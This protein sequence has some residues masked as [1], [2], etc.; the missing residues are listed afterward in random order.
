MT[1]GDTAGNYGKTTEFI[2]YSTKG[3]H[4]LNGKR[5]NNILEFKRVNRK[6]QIHQNQKPVKLLE[7]LISKSTNKGGTVLDPFGGGGSTLIACE[8]T[9]RTCYMMELE[10]KYC[11]R[12]I[13]RYN[14]YVSQ[15]R[16]I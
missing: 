7:Y 13:E 6:K 1:A 12:I 2:I 14:E 16:L 5:D 8:D 15:T 10:E 11:D 3:R 9:G 4:L